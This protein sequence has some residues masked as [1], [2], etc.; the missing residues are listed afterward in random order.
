MEGVDCSSVASCT[1][2]ERGAPECR[3]LRLPPACGLA[4]FSLHASRAILHWPTPLVA[5][6][7]GP[8]CGGARLAAALAR[9]H[10]SV[11]ALWLDH[12]PLPLPLPLRMSPG[13]VGL[14]ASV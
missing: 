11:L 4:G 5:W 12:P 7:G 10:S 2:A 8:G 3:R 13:V 6:R 9:W 14:K 1:P